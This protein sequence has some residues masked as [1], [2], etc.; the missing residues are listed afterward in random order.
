MHK[1][2]KL[3]EETELIL[4]RAFLGK[5][6]DSRFLAKEDLGPLSDKEGFDKYRC[7]DSRKISM[8]YHRVSRKG[9]SVILSTPESFLD[10][11]PYKVSETSFGSDAPLEDWQEWLTLELGEV[12]AGSIYTS[13]WNLD[14]LEESGMDK[15]F[16]PR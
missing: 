2:P 1:H 3:L 4:R 16:R 14:V 5:K 13:E 7:V 12:K 10:N 15:H 9:C 6:M 8:I 11:G